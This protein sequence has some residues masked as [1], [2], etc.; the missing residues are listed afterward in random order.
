MEDGYQKRADIV[1]QNLILA[2]GIDVSYPCQMLPSTTTNREKP[3][4]NSRKA[5]VDIV[6][7]MH[8]TCHSDFKQHGMLVSDLYKAHDLGRKEWSSTQISAFKQLVKCTN[9]STTY[10]PNTSGWGNGG[11]SNGGRGCYRNNTHFLLSEGSP[12]IVPGS[13]EH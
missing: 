4:M 8:L 12:D 9:L 10:N 13:N 2:R 5:L 1:T 6:R 7:A 3:D 11:H